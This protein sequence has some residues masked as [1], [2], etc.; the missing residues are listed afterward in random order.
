MVWLRLWA[1]LHILAIVTLDP[2]LK[3]REELFLRSL[4]FSSKPNPVSPPPVPSILWRIF[5]QRMGSSIQKKKPDL[6]FVEEFNVPGS[7]IRVFPDQGRFIIP[8]S[9]DIHPTQCLEKRLFFNISAIEKEERVTMGSGIEVQ[10]EHLLR[11][12]IDLRLYRTLQITL[13]GMGRSKTSRKLLV[14][15]TFR[16]LHKSLFFNLTEICQSW[17]DPLKNL[18]L[19]LEIFPKKES[20]W[21]STANDE[22]KDIQ[23]FLYT[24]LLTVTLNPL[25]CKR[26][27]RKRSYSKLPFT[28]S[29]ICKKRHLYVEFKD[30]GWQNWVIAPQGYMANYCYGECP[31]P[32]TEILNGS[33]HAIL[34]TLVHSIEPED[35]PLP[36]CV[37]TKMSPISML[38]YDNN[39]NVVLRHYENMAVD[40]CG[41][42]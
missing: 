34:Q 3:R 39:D 20:S 36:C 40:E 22:C 7:V 27:R 38:F 1:F 18:G 25:R 14:A 12:G 13:K 16:L 30:V 8:Y 17:Q 6:C 41:C 42:R 32:L 33:N 19:V 28:A 10:P 5:N 29:N 11:K 15:Q 26:P 35:I 2:E 23:T 37:P 31:Y 21:M 9:D 4:G 24:S